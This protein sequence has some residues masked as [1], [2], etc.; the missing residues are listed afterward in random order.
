M[1][2]Y[3]AV[4][5]DDIGFDIVY[6]N[7]DQTEWHSTAQDAIPTHRNPPENRYIIWEDN[8]GFWTSKETVTGST[9]ETWHQGRAQLLSVNNEMRVVKPKAWTDR[10]LKQVVWKMSDR[11]ASSLAN[12]AADNNGIYPFD[13]HAYQKSFSSDATN[14]GHNH[15][16]G[17]P[18]VPT[19][20]CDRDPRMGE[21]YNDY[22]N[23]DDNLFPDTLGYTV[24]GSLPAEREWTSGNREWDCVYGNPHNDS[25]V[26][27]DFPKSCYIRLLRENQKN[28]VMERTA[29][30]QIRYYV[31]MSGIRKK[32]GFDM[33]DHRDMESREDLKATN[34]WDRSYRRRWSD[35]PMGKS[36]HLYGYDFRASET[37]QND[38]GGSNLIFGQSHHP[39]KHHYLLP[40]Q[41]NQ[42]FVMNAAVAFF[43]NFGTVMANMGITNRP[44]N[45]VLNTDTQWQ[46]LIA[47]LVELIADMR[48]AAE[49][50]AANP[51]EMLRNLK[52]VVESTSQRTYGFY[53]IRPSVPIGSVPG[54]FPTFITSE[55][56]HDTDINALASIRMMED[57]FRSN[58]TTLM[59]EETTV[60]N[61]D[62]M[63]YGCTVNM[64]NGAE[65]PNQLST[66]GGG[67]RAIP[68][69]GLTQMDV[70]RA[71]AGFP[72]P[73]D[74]WH[75]SLANDSGLM[76]FWNKRTQVWLNEYTTGK[77][78]TPY[79]PTFKRIGKPVFKKQLVTA[80]VNEFGM[81]KYNFE[82]LSFKNMS[83]W[84][85]GN[86]KALKDRRLTKVQQ[87]K[88]RFK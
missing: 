22:F 39:I 56:R 74:V 48:D 23:D 8:N 77:T 60:P 73:M 27:C 41:R 82:D 17:T 34:P 11:W 62:R 10:K 4:A 37:G 7:V 67:A 19:V 53:V 71:A 21:E 63:E 30:L 80:E 6:C 26:V 66:V 88:L 50:W 76:A 40:E 70:N 46:Q 25:T 29:E 12:G 64:L 32:D 36:M 24:M 58:M 20:R 52:P 42:T 43:N 68:G 49:D 65:V 44:V 35:I 13:F 15:H 85:K 83:K 3:D 79:P 78:V 33:N 81:W 31:K 16:Y 28:A 72:Q 5:I 84:Q 55:A 86:R 61:E 9:P 54:L 45:Y 38:A 2:N 59:Q 18:M 57:N 69:I 51:T 1:E 47:N 75:N 87:R 14:Y